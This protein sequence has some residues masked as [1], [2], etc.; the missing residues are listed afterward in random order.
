MVDDLP[1][2]HRLHLGDGKNDTIRLGSRREILRGGNTM[3][4]RGLKVLD[5]TLQKTHHW[6]ND[7]ARAAHMD[8]PTAYK[9]LQAVLHAIRDRLPVDEALPTVRLQN[10]GQP[11]APEES[12]RSIFRRMRALH[13]VLRSILDRSFA[14]R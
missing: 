13:V 8:K 5:S 12:H 3:S 10:P 14:D 4:K 7:L 9:S 6:L 2:A 11:I 1:Q